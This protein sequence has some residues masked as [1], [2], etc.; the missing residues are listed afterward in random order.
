[1]KTL[2]NI[3]LLIAI[4]CAGALTARAETTT[5]TLAWAVTT[6]SLVTSYTIE[7]AAGGG[8][9]TLAEGAKTDLATSGSQWVYTDGS[10]PI[11]EDGYARY[12]VR[13]GAATRNEWG[14][15]SDSYRIVIAQEE[16]IPIPDEVEALY[17][18]LDPPPSVPW[19]YNEPGLPLVISVENNTVS[20]PVNYATTATYAVTAGD[21]TGTI[22]TDRYGAYSDLNAEGYLGT[23]SGDLMKHGATAGG[24]L[25][26]Y[27]PNPEIEGSENQ[28]WSEWLWLALDDNAANASLADRR[29]RY[30]QTLIGANTATATTSGLL[31]TGIAFNATD[32]RIDIT[33]AQVDDILSAGHDFTI[34]FWAMPRSTTFV[35]TDYLLYAAT[36]SAG[37]SLSCNAGHSSAY[38]Y[39]Y[40]GGTNTDVSAANVV[41]GQWHHFVLVR[42]GSNV[43]LYYDN[44]VSR[45]STNSAWNVALG[46]N[47]I[48]FGGRSSGN[49]YDGTLDDIRIYARAL[50]AAEISALYNA[51]SGSASP[52]KYLTTIDGVTSVDSVYIPTFLG[53]TASK[54]ADLGSSGLPWDDLYYDDA[55]NVGA[56]DFSTTDV[57]AR[58]IARPPQPKAPG[59]WHDV[60]DEFVE[61]GLA[62]AAELDPASLPRELTGYYRL[63][64]RWRQRTNPVWVLRNVLH[65]SG[66]I[67]A[68]A[69]EAARW[70]DDPPTSYS[71]ARA[72]VREFRRDNRD[73]DELPPAHWG[74]S[75]NQMTSWNYSAVWRLANRAAALQDALDQARAVNQAQ[76]QAL[77]AL[78]ARVK[79][80]EGR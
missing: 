18:E 28:V 42:L 44:T 27:Y 57:L 16:E 58:M 4:A 9:V 55:Y 13:Y 2:R 73:P 61:A 12:R 33:S 38:F 29:G 24:D 65:E 1:M 56:A 31:S 70:D 64:Q 41:D 53:P 15:W 51:R 8:W 26:G 71:L 37:F 47:G 3:A 59:D 48:S 5:V 11:T 63:A 75:T 78:D 36:A 32:R 46:T 60:K 21:L 17:I 76:T 10:C 72:A 67:D 80:L 62:Q 6:N 20:D 23:D 40:N 74:I 43:K 30:G 22:S 50:T 7:R 77:Q 25:S 79:K 68:A 35:G 66:P 52:S 49:Y 39:F 54:G 19:E 34:S 69:F 14:G 45:D